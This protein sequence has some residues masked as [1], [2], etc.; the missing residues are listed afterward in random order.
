MA[1]EMKEIKA[2]MEKLIFDMSK[3]SSSYNV[4]DRKTIEFVQEMK[5]SN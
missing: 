1:L 2:I 5:F 4:M 3:L